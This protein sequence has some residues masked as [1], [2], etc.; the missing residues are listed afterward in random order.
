MGERLK[1]L[2]QAIEALTGTKGAEEVLKYELT[3][4]KTIA[5]EVAAGMEK[6]EREFG[7][8][9]AERDE[10]RGDYK[11]LEQIYKEL[12]EEKARLSKVV[13]D[14]LV[15]MQRTLIATEEERDRLRLEEQRQQKRFND[16]SD[17][18]SRLRQKMKQYRQRRRVY[19]EAEEKIC[20]N[21]QKVY[22]ESENYNWSCRI[23]QS[24]YGDDMW[25][26]CGKPSKEAP[27]CRISKHESKEDDEDADLSKKE[28]EALRRATEKCP[29]LIT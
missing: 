15:A 1:G 3:M 13:R 21:C 16:L 23:H 7:N 26:C 19:G 10:Y 18:F 2:Y 27:G 14:R 5:V 12:K 17:E 20:K 28:Q 29:V 4:L 25:W 11:E 24:E 6:A 22:L 8:A 9:A